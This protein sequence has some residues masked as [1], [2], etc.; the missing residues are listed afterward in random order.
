M[1]DLTLSLEKDFEYRPLYL[2]PDYEGEVRATFI[3]AR[4]NQGN[5]KAVLYIH[6][7]ID[8]FFHPHMAEK[9]LEQGIDFFALELRKYGRSLLPHQHPNYCR[10]M[11]E[12]FEE[13]DT[14][15]EIIRHA[16]DSSTI[17]LMGHSTGGLLACYYLNTGLKK[18][19][20]NAL[21]LNSPFLELN[22]PAVK[23]QLIPPIARLIAT[24]FPFAKQDDALS[25]VYCESLHKDYHGEWDFNLEWKPILGFPAYFAWAKAITDAQSFLKEKSDINIPILLMYSSRSFKPKAYSPETQSA[26]TVL[27]VIDIVERGMSLGSNVTKAEIRDG[28]HDLFLSRKEVR[29]MAF[30]KMF[31]WL[32]QR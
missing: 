25:P 31:E 8:Y 16:Y 11:D 28:M 20:I 22:E 27:N 7:F 9:F 26:D 1:N 12:Y 3:S 24:L 21:I 2:Q 10:K 15:L 32:S 29:E 5:R 30:A 6:G 4:H 19:W 14:A 18:D 23:K 17:I 13:I